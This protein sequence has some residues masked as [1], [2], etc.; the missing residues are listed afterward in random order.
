MAINSS[1]DILY[2]SDNAAGLIY[3]F[4]VSA[5]GTLSQ[6]GGPVNSLGSATGSPGL[7]AIDPTG[8]F[9]YVDDITN[10]VVSLFNITSGTPAFGAFYPTGFTTN[11]P[12]GMDIASLPSATYVLTANQ[13]AGNVWAFQI[14][15][16]GV[17]ATPI[18]SGNVSAP[19][20]IA[21]DP[22]NQFAYTANQGD[23]T[24][25][26]FELNV[27]CPTVVQP[28]CQIGTKATETNPPAGGSAPFDVVLTN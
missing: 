28:V 21:V 23:G 8:S 1:G 2:V 24:V 18:S 10:G 13:T 22:E 14:L 11:G 3:T 27:P 9:L 20:G 15:N 16:S 17:L 25:G 19:T 4:T 6:N 7:M 12:V 26:I 5:S